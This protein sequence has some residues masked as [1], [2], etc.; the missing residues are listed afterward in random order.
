MIRRKLRPEVSEVWSEP[1]LLTWR[2]FSTIISGA[3]SREQNP[4]RGP[5]KGPTCAIQSM[6]IRRTAKTTKAGRWS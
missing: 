4:E 1:W 3:Y 6:T 2:P 5:K